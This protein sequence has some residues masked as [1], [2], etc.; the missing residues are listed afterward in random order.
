M[1]QSHTLKPSPGAKHRPKRIG[2]GNASGHGTS[3]TRGGKGQ[4][5]RSGGSRGLKR[6]GFKNILMATPKLRGFKSLNQ[7]PAEVYLADLEKHFAAGE[8][9]DLA[10]LK[11]KHVIPATAK[12]A[13][14]LTSG[15]LT[16]K[17]I[18]SGIPCTKSALE[19][20]KSLGRG[21]K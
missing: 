10:A 19:K 18:I 14:V 6:L 5:A 9:V 8:T 13:K 7:K 2:R 15:E 21:L 1:L 11:S 17:L 12:A 16:K 20:I 4:T 3:A